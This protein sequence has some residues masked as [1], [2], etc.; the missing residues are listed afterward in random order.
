MKWQL[1]CFSKE[2]QSIWRY[3]LTA[4]EPKLRTNVKSN[5][6]IYEKCCILRATFQ[7]RI[8]FKCFMNIIFAPITKGT[9]KGHVVVIHSQFTSEILSTLHFQFEICIAIMWFH[10]DCITSQCESPKCNVTWVSTILR[11]WFLI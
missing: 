5:V 3:N 7:L 6:N 1:T 8:H 11:N 9:S 4:T 10:F 2:V